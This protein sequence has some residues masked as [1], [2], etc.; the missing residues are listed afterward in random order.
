MKTALLAIDIQDAW[1]KNCPY[2][3]LAIE[4]AVQKA[5]SENI[6]VIWAYM[7]LLPENSAPAKFQ[8]LK[9]AINFAKAAEDKILYR[10]AIEPHDDDWILSKNTRSVF[11]NPENTAF[12]HDRLDVDTLKIVGFRTGQCVLET[13]KDGIDEEFRVIVPPD[14]T[15][16]CNDRWLTSLDTLFAESKVELG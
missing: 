11:G 16:D 2:T 8:D 7:D 12:L 4:D 14:L 1:A 10:P 3:T 13:A 9:L 5:R 15:A 6:P